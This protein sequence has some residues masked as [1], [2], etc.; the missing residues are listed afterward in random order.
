MP[1]IAKHVSILLV[2]LA[3]IAL[4]A[5]DTH[6]SN[7]PQT[8]PDTRRIWVFVQLNVPEEKGQ[9]EDY[10]YY[11]RIANSTYSQI[12]SN[13]LK[14][15]FLYLEDVRYYGNDD[16]YHFYANDEREGEL[17]FRIED[18][19]KIEVLKKPPQVETATRPKNDKSEAEKKSEAPAKS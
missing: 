15:G 7:L 13:E 16:K 19:H 2:V 18:V 11:A 1:S 12:K 6:R 8:P 3:A 9:L 4:A 14:S 17:V 10:Y 5:C